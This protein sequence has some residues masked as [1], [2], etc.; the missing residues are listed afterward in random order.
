VRGEILAPENLGLIRNPPFDKLRAFGNPP[1]DK[2]RAFGN[3][4]FDKLRAFGNPQSEINPCLRGGD[5]ASADGWVRRARKE[6]RPR[7]A[8][9]RVGCA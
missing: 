9:G 4:P 2:L 3:P 7:A 8:R 5:N 6:S 1:F